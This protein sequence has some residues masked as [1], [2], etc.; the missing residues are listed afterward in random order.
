M[1]DLT[2]F[3]AAT[4][5]CTPAA[6]LVKTQSPPAGT[7]V[8]A[9]QTTPVAITVADEAGNEATCTVNLTV[10]ETIAP[11]I[12]TCPPAQNLAADASCAA[13]VPDLTSLTAA[14]DNCTPVGD[15]LMTQNPPAG[16]SMALGS[17]TSVLVTVTDASGNEATCLVN[18][19]VTDQTPPVI[20]SCP[21]DR[22]LAV[23]A[24][25]EATMPDLTVGTLATD[26]CTASD[27]LEKTQN[28][29]PGTTLTLDVVTPVTITVADAAGN[30]ASCT[31][32][33][34]V[35][36]QTAPVITNCPVDQTVAADEVCSAMIPDLASL[37]GAADHCTA[38][39]DL[40]KTQNPPAGT[41]VTLG[42]TT[43]VT[44]VVTDTAGNKVACAVNVM[45]TDQTAPAITRCPP[46]QTL[47]ADVACGATVPDLT[48]ATTASDNCA[49]RGDL[50][51]TQNPPAGTPLTLN[52]TTPI[53]ITVTDPSGNASTCTAN[54][55][56][57]DLMAP[58]ITSCPPDRTVAAEAACEARVPDLT[59]ITTATDNCT[60]A[61]ALVKTQNPPAGTVVTLGLATPVTITV[62][63]AAGNEAN[64]TANVTVTDQT[65][66]TIT[67]CPP[68]RTVAVDADCRAT[69]PD[70][71]SATL[72][73]DNCMPV[74]ELVKTQDPVAGTALTLDS[75]TPV[76]ITIADAAGN[77]ATC[78]VNLTAAEQTAPT[79]TSCAPDQTIAADAACGATLPDLASL[80]TATD[81]CSAADDLVKT[82]NPAA[83]TMLILNSITPVTIM[84][85]DAAGNETTCTA[86][87]TMDDQTAPVI[88]T[89]PPARTLAV[90]AACGATLPDLANSTAATDNCT[91]PGD[92]VKTQSPPPGTALALAA[93]TPVTITVADTSGN[94]ATCIVNVT[95]TDQTA[96]VITS[97]PSDR[98]LAADAAC[99]A[100]IPDLASSALA[101]DNC[102]PAGGLVKTQSPLAGTVVTSGTITPVTITIAD[103]AGNEAMCSV[104]V[105]VTDQTAPLIMSCPPDRT[106]AADAVCGATVP[107]LV[108]AT[109]ASDNC[110]P[111]EELITTQDPPV[112]TPLALNS[113]TPIIVTVR[114]TSG[115]AATCTANVTV[116]DQM[117][118]VITACPPD[119]MLAADN[120]CATRI[121]DLASLAAATDN[122]TAVGGLVKT[123]N[124]PAGTVVTLG[125]VTP[126]TITVA[127]TAGNEATCTVNVTVTDQTAP[128][129]T[130]CPPDRTVAVDADCQATVPD[131][132][133]AILATDNCTPVGELVKRQA[134][135]A[136]TALTVGSRTPVTITI[137]DAAGNEA[138]C[139]VNL[140]AAEQTAPT[141]TACAP[142]QTIAADAACGATL[143]DLASL[144]TATDNCSAADDLVKTQNPVAG[145]TLVLD[146][147]TPIIITVRDAAGNE[148]TCTAAVT[149]TDQ[150]APVITSCPSDQTI[151]AD[152]AC[153]AT[154]PD[155]ASSTA[156][157]D[158]CTTVSGLL[159]TQNPP[160]GTVIALGI[161]T[162][163]TITIADAAGNLVTCV[164][165]V[166]VT[167]QAAPVVTFCPPGRTLA[168]DA[169][170]EAVVP[171]LTSATLAAD[172]C[173]A[174][175]QLLK[176]QNPSAGMALALGTTTPVTLTVTD[177]AGNATTC[178][179][180]FTATDQTSP[181]ISV[182]PPDR[183]L[184]ADAACKAT[185]PD[186]TSSTAAID[187]CTSPGDL[188]KTQNPPAGTALTLGS[189][190][191]IT[192][193]VMDL[194]GNTTTCTV[195]LTVVDQVAPVIMSCPPDQTVAADAAC[196]AT[197]PDLASSTAA[198]DNCTAP[199]D[200][201][202][203]QNPSPG[204]DLLWG[205]ITPVT[206]TVAD[207]AGNKATCIVNVTVTDQTA[208]VITSCPSDRTLAAD[209]ACAA[210]IPDLASSTAATDNCTAPGDLVTTQNP[211]PGTDLLLG[212]ITPVT[213]TVADIAGNK[214][215]CIVNVT[216]T[217]QTAPVI[218][219]CPSDRTLA[220]DAACAATIP[221]LAS[222]TA[223]TDNCTPAGNLMRTQN[224]AAGT[225]LAFNSFTPVTITIADTAGNE[226]KC[227]VTV[228][229]TDQTAPLIT[230]CPPDRTLAADAVCGATVPD[231]VD[232]TEAS[233]NC[234]ST[235][236]LITTQDPAVGTPLAL[237]STTPIIVTV[238]DTSGN[239]A[240]CTAN[241]TV[242]DQMVPV[243]TACPPDRT[244]AADNACVTTL[245][246][247]ASLTAA[248]DNCTAAGDLT[249]T[250][251]PPAGTVVTLG[252]VTSVLI[253]V[254]DAAGNQA[255][256]TANVT[257]TDQTAP[258]I[259]TC[260]PD[261]T[262]A[263]DA[264][265]RATVPDLLS[266]T[267]ATDNCTPVGEL[268]KRQDPLAGTALTV[269]SRTP[270][271]MTIAD[272][273]GNE[274]MC[275]VNLT[276]AGADCP[277]DYC[278][279]AGP[280]HRRGCRLRRNAS[281]FDDY[282]H[283]NGQL[284]RSR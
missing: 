272:A 134:P 1:P 18:I 243:I 98:T 87:V 78:V 199:G 164:A 170:C 101:T 168:A 24:A 257:V 137:A 102:T 234:T 268:V 96:P 212:T 67:T 118:P 188:A 194:S 225:V 147:V 132:L 219:S 16:A 252:A 230:T 187:N 156:A 52:S 221:D 178:T 148:A 181:M 58:V 110:A 69:V 184:A 122:C 196:A 63:D 160:S 116:V 249:K 6:N 91:P 80:T 30:Q 133:S 46:D 103:T 282:H 39:G 25:C 250:Q 273:A 33:V 195:N 13:T 179:V 283:G 209:A 270:V 94:Q 64:C 198:T 228:T 119:R 108:D 235:D 61:G 23:N 214:A 40:V 21:S 29:S 276:A 176:T 95:A 200:L 269:G 121:P 238:R 177:T 19:A 241:V 68:D 28:P 201:V 144:T 3:T 251:N 127:D 71:L 9:G 206:I 169:A 146:S 4:D 258:T 267:L 202:T 86:M 139:V 88:T 259:T 112:G 59:G 15:L 27:N 45:V 32:N 48:S 54:L 158:N 246:D 72:A 12:T 20:T 281:G 248:T 14:T 264:A 208:P 229:V 233:D 192:L 222:S 278:L 186:L 53:I 166:T 113:T 253:S 223:A 171:D 172:N 242:V 81:N 167:D 265:C 191:P 44:I 117:A 10:T 143:P 89:C 31:V 17:A 255:T 100:T 210:T 90:D 47:A 2:K 266:D 142:D 135:P 163:V 115:N 197:L 140:T 57:T 165:T 120:A 224:P 37:T 174:A 207:I 204:T 220:A 49:P 76:M 141:I 129:I 155:L 83:G 157:T 56:A 159:K 93:V 82:Q 123:Q 227:S 263:V 216:V 43:P 237:N 205:T 106:L 262:V 218:T 66:P 55:T 92:L 175:G 280:D 162:P 97:C 226:A 244:L 8:A 34:T 38:P 189:T 42:T 153:A 152:A 236:D 51:K 154:L 247:L 182:C 114:D 5:N 256:C 183:T 190:T 138:M 22:T 240:A 136:G 105:T 260:P 35:A 254:A 125:A 41:D 36:D 145:T 277:H 180:N 75:R 26:N 275:V 185:V 215:T 11:V 217:D 245:P 150:T 79:I 131:L 70:L 274:A 193:T 232:A 62:A 161:A 77:E 211:S 65:A 126:V 239:A 99:A 50:I 84:I 284:H 109:E 124:P 73:T 85:T 279:C 231:L 74:G 60:A 203:T 149:V 7:A 261:R 107:D 213:I 173:T 111:A 128:A 130:T 271:T 104:N 151:A